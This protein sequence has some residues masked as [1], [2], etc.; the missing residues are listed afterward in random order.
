MVEYVLAGVEVEIGN[1]ANNF[2]RKDI[3]GKIS[4]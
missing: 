1:V 3:F 4:E 2:K